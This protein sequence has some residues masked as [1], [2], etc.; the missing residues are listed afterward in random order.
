MHTLVIQL[1]RLGDVVQTTPLPRELAAAGAGD[2]GDR[3]DLLLLHPNQAAVLGI[4]CIA[5]IRTMGEDLRPL[6]DQIAAGFRR[7]QIPH[8]QR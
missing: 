4:R 1:G 5:T 8:A 2:P 3:I 6:D 7:R